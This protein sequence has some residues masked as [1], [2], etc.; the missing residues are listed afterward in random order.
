M[1]RALDP[2]ARFPLI[3]KSDRDKPEPRPTFWARYLSGRE[4]IELS[5]AKDPEEHKLASW[6]NALR[7]TIVDW[8]HLRDKDGNTIR[9][10]PAMFENVLDPGEARELV[11]LCVAGQQP[12][13]TEKKESGPRQQSKPANSVAP[14]GQATAAKTPKQPAPGHDSNVQAAPAEAVQTVD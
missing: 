8:Q 11:E 10:A 5:N 1:P 6:Y 2:D 13:A 4:W 14:V 3:L 9:F 7:M 12:D